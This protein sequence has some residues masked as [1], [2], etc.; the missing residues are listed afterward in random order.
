MPVALPLV[1]F[2]IL[3]RPLPAQTPANKVTYQN[4]GVSAGKLLKDLSAQTGQSLLT[5]PVTDG[6]VLAIRL[7]DVPLREAM[8]KIAWA[9]GGSW[10]QEGDAFRLV[11]TSEDVRA[12]QARE[13]N[14]LIEAFR[15]ALTRRQEELAKAEEFNAARAERMAKDAAAAIEGFT[16]E[17]ADPSFWRFTNRLA[18]QSPVGRAMTRILGRVVP[19]DLADLPKG[20][21][22][23]YSTNPTR[24]QRRLTS[25][26]KPVIATLQ[27]EQALWV[28]M[29]T[30]FNVKNPVIGNSTYMMNG[31]Q[32]ADR[33]IDSIGKVLLVVVRSSFTGIARFELLIADPKGK[34]VARSE[35]SLG[36]SYDDYLKLVTVPANDVKVPQPKD[37][38]ALASRAD[39]ASKA[40]I[41]DDLRQRLLRPEE[42]EPMGILFGN[43]LV[44][45]GE[46]KRIN[47]VT[48]ISD[49]SFYSLVG[50][51]KEVPATQII[52]LLGTQY[53]T[54][55]TP[56][57]L[58]FR[59]TA[60]V[61]AR[62]LRADRRTLGPYLRRRA[63]PAPLTVEEQAM[64]AVRLP[65][66]DAAQLANGLVNLVSDDETRFQ[67]VNPRQLRLLGLL[68]KAQRAAARQGGLPLG[69]LTPEQAGLLQEM[70]YGERGRLDFEGRQAAE[71]ELYNE[72]ILKEPT[73]SLPNG[74]PPD[75]RLVIDEQSEEVA[76]TNPANDGQYRQGSQGYSAEEMGAQQFRQ[77][78]PDLFPGQDGPG[79]K[80]DFRRLR[81]GKRTR[82]AV[83]IQF[84]PNLTMQY[85]LEDRAYK[86]SAPMPFE[87]L[88]AD[89]RKRVQ[90]SL[91]EQQRQNQPPPAPR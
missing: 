75:G 91:A 68:T 8:E 79:W 3:S 81:L 20:I 72:G 29:M 78:R 22:I 66:D 11:R 71:N 25:E 80:V 49:T 56:E 4:P 54:Q 70:V 45:L 18:E 9:V 76:F 43:W 46:A 50:R 84:T 39:S 7:S 59:P 52:R 89:F 15:K 60:A 61:S 27:R 53:E 14:G 88:P 86:M 82:Y 23:V 17:G 30:R 12:E 31:I 5:S 35:A 1:V 21:K 67:Y 34:I 58:A 55:E 73:E 64:W 13:R 6:E 47:L 51:Q 16:P 33:P 63:E 62:A 83:R 41:P 2:V 28:D 32:G 42:N 65:V 38:A 48:S 74:I 19:A 85:R 77:S 44:A 90:E 10:K 26:V 40:A 37:A 36:P 87:Q 69:S 57:W 24:T